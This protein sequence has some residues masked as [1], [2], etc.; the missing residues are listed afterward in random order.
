MSTYFSLGI[1]WGEKFRH[2]WRKK[3]VW[4]TQGVLG[5]PEGYRMLKNQGTGKNIMEAK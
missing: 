5:K 2:M 1:T 4:W 3:E